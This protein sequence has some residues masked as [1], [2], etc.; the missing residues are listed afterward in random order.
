M[1]WEPAPVGEEDFKVWKVLQDLK[2]QGQVK[3]IGVSNF[4]APQLRQLISQ[5]GVAPDIIQNRCFAS[6]GW[7]KEVRS[8]CQHHG[9]LYQGFS[10]LTANINELQ[11]EFIANLC[12]KYKKTVPQLVFR[13]CLQ[14]KY[15]R[16][17]RDHKGSTYGR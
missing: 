13:F 1:N 17:H 10:L 11:N 3:L 7:D 6:K 2:A 5:S 14:K 4:S 12:R 9:I 15:D 8:V 16:S